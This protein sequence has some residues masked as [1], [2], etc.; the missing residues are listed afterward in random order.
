MTRLQIFYNFM[1][2]LATLSK[3]EDKKQAAIIVTRDLSQVLSIGLNG[4][5]KHGIDCLCAL[6]GKYSCIHAEV[7]AIIKACQPVDTCVMLC[8]MS[9]CVTCATAIVNSGIKRV[10]YDKQYKSTEGINILKTAGIA[11][12]SFEEA[13]IQRRA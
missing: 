2:E 5:P 3:C 6:G 7:Q 4:G 11:V 12:L 10:Y 13:G 8:T 9:P 1:F